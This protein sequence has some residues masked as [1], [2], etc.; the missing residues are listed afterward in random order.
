[1]SLFRQL[2][3][4]LRS[5]VGGRTAD[6]DVDD[7]VQHYLEQSAAAHQ[8]RGLTRAE[9]VRAARLEIGSATAVR[10]QVRTSGWEHTLETLLTDVRYAFRRLGAHPGFTVTA[11]A[12][13]AIGIGA[14]TTVFSAISPILLEPLPFPHASRLV[15]IADR[16]SSGTPMPPTFG[17]YAE[18]RARA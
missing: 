7:E 1:M 14:C 6:R 5:L 9:A 11:V 15:T 4:G 12:T 10:E 3:R 2:T 17:T 18:I 13:L 16:T 8:G